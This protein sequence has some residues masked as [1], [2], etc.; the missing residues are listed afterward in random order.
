MPLRQSPLSSIA[1]THFYWYPV[2][3]RS[4]SRLPPSKIIPRSTV[5]S[6]YPCRKWLVEA[7]NSC[8]SWVITLLLSLMNWITRAISSRSW[9]TYSTRHCVWCSYFGHKMEAEEEDWAAPSPLS[10]RKPQRAA[11]TNRVIFCGCKRLLSPKVDISSFKLGKSPSSKYR[12]HGTK[13]EHF[14]LGVYAPLAYIATQ[15]HTRNNYGGPLKLATPV[16]IFED[17]DEKRDFVAGSALVSPLSECNE[18]RSSDKQRACR[19]ARVRSRS[20]APEGPYPASPVHDIVL[21]RVE[22]VHTKPSR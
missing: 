8:L 5:F 16:I 21:A 14:C 9:D 4:L 18:A 13:P 3:P 15:K 1:S 7:A 11:D 12:R 2:L 20:L 6:W 10:V 19:T 17:V 22:S